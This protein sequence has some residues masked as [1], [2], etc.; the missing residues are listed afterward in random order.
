MLPAIF[1]LTVE[2]PALTTLPAGQLLKS[3]RLSSIHRERLS[4]CVFAGR[5][6]DPDYIGIS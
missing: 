6:I 4:V 1:K 5:V 2:L 3:I